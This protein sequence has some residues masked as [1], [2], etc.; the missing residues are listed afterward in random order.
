M[1]KEDIARFRQQLITR[2]KEGLWGGTFGSAEPAPARTPIPERI[3]SAPP[4]ETERAKA[5]LRP[6][7]RVASGGE[8]RFSYLTPEIYCEHLEAF[9]KDAAKL[10]TDYR[11]SQNGN[12]S[13]RTERK[14]SPHSFDFTGYLERIQSCATKVRENIDSDHAYVLCRRSDTDQVVCVV[15]LERAY[16]LN[17]G[18]PEMRMRNMFWPIEGLPSQKYNTVP[19]R[20]VRSKFQLRTWLEGE[21]WDLQDFSGGGYDPYGI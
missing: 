2:E 11:I 21:G 7:V 20:V 19:E 12:G 4:P 8:T 17:G 9:A 10:G 18:Q 13:P 14:G 16:S 1:S 3:I 5:P 6:A 15:M